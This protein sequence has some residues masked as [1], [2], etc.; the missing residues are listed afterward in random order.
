MVRMDELH[1][2]KAKERAEQKIAQLDEL[3][4]KMLPPDTGHHIDDVDPTFLDQ[5]DA[6]QLPNVRPAQPLRESQV[7]RRQQD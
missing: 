7:L 6:Q 2:M 5:L 1:R 4:R 3:K